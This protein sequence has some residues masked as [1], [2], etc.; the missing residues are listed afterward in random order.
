VTK[1]VYISG[2]T[3]YLGNLISN[4]LAAL[5]NDILVGGRNP[6]KLNEQVQLLSKTFTQTKIKSINCQLENP[7]DWERIAR[8]VVYHG[9]DAYINCSAI[10]G[11]INK[12][13]KLNWEDID[14]VMRINLYS[15][16][17]FTNFFTNYSNSGK[18]L[19]VI[20]FSGGGGTTPRQNFM[21]YS[22][23]KTALIRFV[24]NFN[25]ENEN[26]NVAINIVS[27][28]I[29]PSNMQY[30]ILDSE[31]RSDDQEVISAKKILEAKIN[32]K[33]KVLDLIEFLLSEKSDGISGKSISAIWDDWEE[34]PQH[35]SELQQSDLYTLRRITAKNHNLDWG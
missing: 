11:K 16:I 15:S 17:F 6:N 7:H 22:L 13:L 28:G 33:P 25:L 9:I 5:G 8:E 32:E 3:G 20:H 1:T 14:S 26:L 4:R 29:L 35:L 18:Q 23:S 2:A 12:I 21:P 19:K 27:P 30:E 24:E 34:W 31:L 10:Q